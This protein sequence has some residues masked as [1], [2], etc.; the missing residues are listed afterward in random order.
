FAAMDAEVAKARAALRAARVRLF[1][2]QTG[3]FEIM[4]MEELCRPRPAYILAR[5][6]Y[7]SP[8]TPPVR[9]LTPQAL[10]PFPPGT[11]RN[12]LG[13]ARWLTHPRHPLTARVAVNRFWQL[14]FGRG[15]VVTTE[16]FGTQGA[17]PTHP[18]LL[19][20][21]ARD[22]VASGWD[23]KRLCKKIVLSSTY[24]QR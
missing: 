3:V 16:N 12:R 15:L 20:W 8:K 14:F 23:L 17:L 1:A 21:L 24:R 4:T 10:P 9:R 18:E 6:R 7:D 2:A 19:D 11:P 22:F 13:L 5:G